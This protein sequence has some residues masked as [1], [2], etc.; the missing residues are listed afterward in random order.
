LKIQY[1]R[2]SKYERQHP[3]VTVCCYA[4]GKREYPNGYQLHMPAIGSQPEI[5]LGFAVVDYLL[6]NGRHAG[7]FYG[8]GIPTCALMLRRNVLDQFGGF[9]ENLRRV[10]DAD[11][12]IRIGLTGGHFIGC[13]E[14]LFLQYATVAPDK[15]PQK[16]LDSELIILEKNSKYL[17]EKSLYYYAVHW[18]MLRYYHF[19]KQYGLI[20]YTLT[21]ILLR[22]PIRTVRH[23]LVSGPNRLNHEKKIASKISRV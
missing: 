22:Y 12:A 15:T 2:L 8:A 5:P 19:N 10:E 23:L 21:K 9:D 11:L 4:S 6:F 3:Q 16:N 20:L 17:R 13:R 14:N 7:V 1:E 18:A